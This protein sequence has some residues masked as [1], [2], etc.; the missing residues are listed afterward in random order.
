MSRRKSKIIK[1]GNVYIGG[2]SPI[3]IQSMAKTK[4]SDIEKTI[5]QISSL[6]KVGCEI[7]RLAVKDTADAGALKKIKQQVNL[8]LVADIHFNW[9][10]ALVAIDNGVDKIRLNPGNIYKKNQI[11]EIVSA[12]K[13]H[14]VPIRVGVNS[15]SLRQ[16][17]KAGK[18][19]ADMLVKSA[20]DYIR[21]LEKFKFY[22]IVVSL[23]GTGVFDTIEAYRKIA[24]LCAY[25]LHL[26][27]TATGPQYLG[28]I[29]S[30][31]AIGGLLLEGIGDT[32]RVSLT[33]KPETEVKVAKSILESVAAR[34]FGPQI[35][36]CPTCGRCEVDLVKIVKEL[37]KKISTLNHRLCAR[38]LKVAVMG[39]V[40]NGPGEARGVDI[41]VAFGKKEGLLFKNGK[42]LRKV[43]FSNCADILIKEMENAGA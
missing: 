29:K 34:F 4:T 16:S 7:V 19:T 5:R 32:I 27:V 22:E 1:I 9:R 33:D 23:K 8:P 43:S 25:P 10:F 39:C 31:I 3:A 17:V 6:E 38:P 14:K 41:G 18:T 30:S 21:I 20:L 11:R 15:G 40:V 13:L 24:K 35:I 26:G 12:A 2:N 28:S 42:P 37:E 36:S